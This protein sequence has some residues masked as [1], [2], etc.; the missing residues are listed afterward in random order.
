MSDC[1]KVTRYRVCFAGTNGKRRWIGAT[2]TAGRTHYPMQSDAAA[3]F[4]TFTAAEAA[5]DDVPTRY[6]IKHTV[7]DIRA[8]S[9]LV[10]A[11]VDTKHGPLYSV[12]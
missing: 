5:A 7:P 10:P 9:V 11:I 6:I 8:V 2:D 12:M 1:I 4:P 3:Q